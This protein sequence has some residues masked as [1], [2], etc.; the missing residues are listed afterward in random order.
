[1]ANR[2]CKT[3]S[4]ASRR[5][6][7]L[8]L[9]TAC[10]GLSGC[11]D[12]SMSD[13]HSYSATVLAREGTRIDELPPIEPYIVYS[14]ASAASAQPDPFQPFLRESDRDD[15][16]DIAANGIRP[17]LDRNKEELE[18][19]PLDGLRMMGT[20]VREESVWGVVRSPDGTIHRVSVG[21][22]MGRNHGK[23]IGIFEDK[24]EL[25]EIIPD[26]QGGWQERSAGL[27]LIE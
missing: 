15:T 21:N 14:Y 11:S 6:Q 26:G 22:Y 9:L 19:T 1:M 20:L 16:A 10:I 13:L 4:C 18:T 27:A 25:Q 5:V 23:I 12:Q 8:T 24:I 2:A 7:Y 3:I 17:D